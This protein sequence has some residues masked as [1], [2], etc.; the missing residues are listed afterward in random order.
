MEEKK[1]A[2]VTVNVECSDGYK[3]TVS[4][5]TAIVFMVSNAYEF[6]KGDVEGMEG[7]VVYVGNT[8]PFPIFAEAIADLI[9]HLI[10]Q[11]N[12]NPAKAAYLLHSIASE[13][14]KESDNQCK[15]SAET[16]SDKELFDRNIEDLVKSIFC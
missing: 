4:G 10:Q 14:Q 2:A 15:I 16:C 8:L 13:L 7:G 11:S 1:T 12:E 9:K 5:D 3:E 6:L